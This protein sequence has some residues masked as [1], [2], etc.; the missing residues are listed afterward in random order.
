MNVTLIKYR[1]LLLV[2]VLALVAYRYF[3]PLGLDVGAPS[4][5]Q[6]GVVE[7]AFAEERSGLWVKVQG[8]VTRLLDDDRD[9]S[10]HQRFILELDSGHTVMV[11]HNI[12]LAQRVPLQNNSQ[13]V[14][15]GR[16]E[17]NARGGVIHWTHHDPEHGRTGGWI[18]FNGTVYR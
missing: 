8:R 5:D 14:V 9:G 16:Y 4:A 6:S 12:D 2:A 15:S 17:W 10:R 1:L 11:A 13:L 3:E 7:T 18:E